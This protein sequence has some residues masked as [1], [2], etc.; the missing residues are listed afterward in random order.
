MFFR[1]LDKGTVGS[2]LRFPQGNGEGERTDD[3]QQFDQRLYSLHIAGMRGKL[4][5]LFLEA[6]SY[7]VFQRSY[8]QSNLSVCSLPK[9]ALDTLSIEFGLL[10]G[11]AHLA[12]KGNIRGCFEG[13][14]N[15]D[16]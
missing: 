15:G 13:R 14:R 10:E 2:V 5:R 11:L 3:F 8:I 9:V 6:L 1:S 16:R 4:N 12:I 7:H